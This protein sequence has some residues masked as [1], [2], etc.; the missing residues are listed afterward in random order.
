[1]INRAIQ[2]ERKDISDLRY[3][4]PRVLQLD[5][6]IPVYCI[7]KPGCKIARVELI[8]RA[9][10]WHQN[11]RLQASVCVQMLNEGFEGY[12]SERIANELDSMGSFLS[13]SSQKHTATICL[14]SLSRMMPEGLNILAGMLLGPLFPEK[15]FSLLM[16]QRKQQHQ[17]ESEKVEYI[18]AKK[19]MHSLFGGTHPYG[20]LVQPGDFDILE[21][22]HLRQFHASRYT[23]SNCTV[24][25]AGDISSGIIKSLNSLLGSSQWGGSH[26]MEPQPRCIAPSVEKKIWIERE[27][28]VQTAFR[29]GLPVI[30]KLHPDFRGLQVLN[31]LLGGYF[32]SRLMSN[33]R[34]DKGY[35]YGIHSSL[36]SLKDQG[37]FVISSQIGKEHKE[38]ALAEIYA[39]IK[40]LREEPVPEE[41]LAIVKNYMLGQILRN[42]DGPFS[43]ADTLKSL[44]EYKL[45]F[46]YYSQ[47]VQFIKDIKP[48]HLQELAAKYWAAGDFY[49]IL[50]G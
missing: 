28:A 19:F 39:E 38:K 43:Q 13:L 36:A 11:T 10:D 7:D 16:E 3:Q 8:F 22:E 31:T 20:N 50:V 46:S 14:H 5:N 44:L 29:L 34:E 47:S 15:E 26:A 4:D 32:G 27:D 37:Y 21:P 42:F 23:H 49:E 1:L 9:G 41:E 6:G 40:K 17:V 35:T 12:S 45:G 25:A 30:N 18:A 2:P 24:V 33:L 48:E